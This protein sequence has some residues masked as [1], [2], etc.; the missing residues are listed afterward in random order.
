MTSVWR[1]PLRV[2]GATGDDDGSGALRPERRRTGDHA[3]A[4]ACGCD[5]ERVVDKLSLDLVATYKLINKRYY[6]E[7]MK[8]TGLLGID[9]AYQKGSDA[10]GAHTDANHNYIFHPQEVI[11]GRYTVTR[12]LGTGSFG[13]VVEAF[14]SERGHPVALKIIKTKTGFVPKIIKTLVGSHF[15]TLV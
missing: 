5:R 14:D 13:E 9:S 7:K 11:A 4:A 6:E 12:K 1:S 8:Q 3:S 2:S 15:L 10:R